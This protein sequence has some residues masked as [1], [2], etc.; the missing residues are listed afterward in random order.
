M[1]KTKVIVFR[2]GGPL[3][4]YERWKYGEHVLETVSYY[5]Y[6]GI[7]FSSRNSWYM[8]QK[9]L[10]NQASKALFAVKSRLTQFGNVNLSVMFKIFDTKILP[11][12][13]YGSEIWFSHPSMDIEKVHNQFCKYVLR[14]PIY[15]TN[16]FARSELGRYKLEVFKYL[17][18]IKYWLRVLSLSD[19][20]IP[21]LC[22]KMQRRWVANDTECWLFHIRNLLFSSGFGEA[23]LNQGVGNKQAFLKLFKQRLKDMDMQSLN[24]D[25]Q[26][27]DRLRTYKILKV[28]FGTESYLF[29]I[30][31]TILRTLF[32]KFR[33][34]LLKLEGNMGRYPRVPFDTRLCPLCHSDVETEFHFLMICPCLMTVRRKYLTAIWY[35]YPSINKFVQLC[36]SSNPNTVTS[37]ARYILCAMKVR[38]NLL[39]N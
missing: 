21:K 23:W 25:I 36:N 22:Y 7:L 38:A 12:L 13:L 18:A 8:S 27:M 39:T 29:N 17:K 3:R 35:M 20:R 26:D 16:V 31:N 33:G 11:I 15:A 32:S 37:I 1:L 6:L 5:K 34:G 24:M 9:T 10:A 19:G 14:L 4:N 28:R 30:K 2:N